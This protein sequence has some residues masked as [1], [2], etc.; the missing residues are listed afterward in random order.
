M[1]PTIMGSIAATNAAIAASNASSLSHNGDY[2]G[3]MTMREGGIFSIIII[4]WLAGVTYCL[5][6]ASDEYQWMNIYSVLGS[7]L[8][9]LPFVLMIIFG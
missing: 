1:T 8:F 5:C 9:L 7:C 6:K 2:T 4:L 3:A